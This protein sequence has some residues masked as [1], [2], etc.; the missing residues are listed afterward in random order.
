[1]LIPDISMAVPRPIAPDALPN[2]IPIPQPIAS[3]LGL[4]A[5]QV[6]SAL[7]SGSGESMQLKL[8]NGQQITLSGNLQQFAGTVTLKVRQF[9]QNLFFVPQQIVQSSGMKPPPTISASLLNILSRSGNRQTIQTFLTY[10]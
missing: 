9:G 6:V 8:S 1:M 7:L 4:K 3:E 2:Q 5:G 10:G